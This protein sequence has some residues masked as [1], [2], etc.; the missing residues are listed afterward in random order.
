MK[1]RLGCAVMVLMLI[2]Y[3]GIAQVA[4]Y[5]GFVVKN[6]GDTIKGKVEDW[7]ATSASKFVFFIE[8]GQKEITPF[9][10]TQI[11][12]YGVNGILYES[13]KMINLNKAEEQVFLQRLVAGKLSVY[14]YNSDFYATRDTLGYVLDVTKSK[15][16]K[17]SRARGLFKLL[18]LDCKT[19]SVD[20]IAINEAG[21]RSLANKYNRCVNSPSIEY[22]SFARKKKFMFGVI[23]GENVSN[24]KMTKDLQAIPPN[25]PYSYKPAHSYILGVSAEFGLPDRPSL[26]TELSYFN[27]NFSGTIG[28]PTAEK[29]Y[30]A[31]YVRFSAGVR[32]KIRSR[33]VTPYVGLGASQLF[34]TKLSGLEKNTISSSNYSQDVPVLKAVNP[35]GLW[36]SI[37]LQK[38]FSQ[39][40]G[41]KIEGRFE[42]TNGFIEPTT[43]AIASPVNTVTSSS[44]ISNNS[45]MLSII[46]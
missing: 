29:Y 35:Q 5:D 46:F 7:G 4:R 1:S 41:I 37:G 16:E 22:K 3:H 6:E 32:L 38:R 13:K 24:L 44:S 15:S 9:K 28:T 21:L 42:Q 18:V 31:S 30:N 11:M 26:Y 23:V 17:N 14:R 45:L 20:S 10:P 40:F 12:G 39:R 25:S 19:I 36:V 43:V 2:S 27:T 34:N 8:N 33:F